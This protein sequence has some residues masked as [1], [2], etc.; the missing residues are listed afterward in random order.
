MGD[1]AVSLHTLGEGGLF[2]TTQ[3]SKCHVLVKFS[4]GGGIL[5]KMSKNFA[6]PNSG[7]PCIADSLSHTMCMETKNIP[8]L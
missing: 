3:N 4:W 1:T 5:G 7:R 8:E 2:L 6:M